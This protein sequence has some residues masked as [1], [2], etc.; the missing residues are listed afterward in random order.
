MKTIVLMDRIFVTTTKIALKMNKDE[1]EMFGKE[2]R[3]SNGENE[4]EK[5]EK[6][7]K[8]EDEEPHQV[9]RESNEDEGLDEGH[10]IAVVLAQ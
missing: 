8:K 1:D 3:N 10:T 9:G 7:S 2:K 6:T 4:Q 5:E